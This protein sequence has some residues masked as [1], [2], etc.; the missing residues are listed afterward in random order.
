[1]SIEQLVDAR[2]HKVCMN[3]HSIQ[4][5][6]FLFSAETLSARHII[7]YTTHSTYWTVLEREENYA[8]FEEI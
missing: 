7:R 6:Y 8:I 5:Q 3:L 4:M 1:M 2:T